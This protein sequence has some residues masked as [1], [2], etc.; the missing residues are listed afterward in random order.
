M[1]KLQWVLGG[2]LAVVLLAA[3]AGF[4]A[5]WKYANQDVVPDGVT[6]GKLQLG[7]MYIDDAVALL[8]KYEKALEKRSITVQANEAANDSASWVVSDFGYRAEF[9][10]AREA[11]LKLRRGSLWERARYRYH[12]PSHYAL[13]QSWEKSA[14]EAALRKQWSWVENNA[15]QN[16]TREITK[17]D[18]VIYTPHTDAYRLD[19]AALADKAEQWMVL[20]DNQV[21]EEVAG[22]RGALVAELPIRTIHPEVT[23]EKLKKEGIDRLI[24]TFTTDFSSSAEGRAHN[25]SVTA[26]SLNDWYLGPDEVFAY[27]ELI[28]KAEKEHTYREAPVIL[29]G[30]FVP[31]IGGGICQVSSTLYQA[32]LRAGLGIEERRNHSLPVAYLPLGHD[33]TYATDAIDFKFRNTTGKSLIIRTSVENKKLTIKLFGTMPGNESYEIESVTLDTIQPKTQQSV[34]PALPVGKTVVVD[35]GKPGY[36]VETYRTHLRDGKVVSRERVSKDTYRAQPTLIETGPASLNATPS[37][38]ATPSPSDVIE[39]GL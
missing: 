6:A 37:P 13:S 18:E 25:V 2:L 24:M 27:S 28:A 5:V 34:N 36:V 35:K 11:L 30:K 8:E 20:E 12:F 22:E 26:Q 23:L 17:Q 19:L 3:A 10:G 32:V 29:N 4:V 31:G 38:Q 9:T 1:R 14:F 15:P 21:G 33:A 7:G 16:A 39:D